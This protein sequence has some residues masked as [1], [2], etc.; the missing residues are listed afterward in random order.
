MNLHV[1][2]SLQLKALISP[3]ICL[4][5]AACGQK[6]ALYIPEPDQ[7]PTVSPQTLP[8]PGAAQPLSFPEQQELPAEEED[9]ISE[10]VGTDEAPQAPE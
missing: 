10:P 5:L 7:Q 4:L 2:R 6:G 3:L 8:E 9:G 1:Q